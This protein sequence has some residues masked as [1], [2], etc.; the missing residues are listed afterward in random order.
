MITSDEEI[1]AAGAVAAGAVD[2][3][4]VPGRIQFQIARSTASV[5]G[6]GSNA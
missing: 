6:F 1:D 2:H 4:N 5:S 3:F